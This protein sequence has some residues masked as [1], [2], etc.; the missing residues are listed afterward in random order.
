[1]R[2]FL[3][4]IL[5]QEPPQHPEGGIA[6]PLGAALA[7]VSGDRVVVIDFETSGLSPAQGDRVIEVGAVAIEGDRIVDRFA[8]LVNPGFKVSSFISDYT[9]ITNKMLA[10]A[11]PAQA[12]IPQMCSFIGTAGM[13]AH[14]ASFDSRFLH[15]ETARTGHTLPQGMACSM[16]IARRVYQDLCSHSLEHL[17]QTKNLPID[18]KHHRALADAEMTAHLWIRMISDLKSCYGL[19]HIPFDTMIKLAKIPKAKVHA[20]MSELCG[21]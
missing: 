1:M 18:G 15:A 14:N 5:G 16:L 9:G 6:K 19:E 21:G 20:F 8:S 2:R 11:P 13:V 7:G 4:R 3:Q 17:V 10:G 12:V